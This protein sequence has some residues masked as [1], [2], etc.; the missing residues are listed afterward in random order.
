MEYRFY[1]SSVIEFSLEKI[2]L[3]TFYVQVG[4]YCQIVW[5]SLLGFDHALLEN[6][7]AG[8]Y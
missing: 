1:F 3:S 6:T 2:P 5:I 4:S 7:D 8:Q